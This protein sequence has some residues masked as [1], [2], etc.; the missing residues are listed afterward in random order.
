MYEGP[1][2]E[3]EEGGKEVTTWCSCGDLGSDVVSFKL[4]LVSP[5]IVEAGEVA[6]LAIAASYQAYH[7][8]AKRETVGLS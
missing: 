2:G 8:A 6:A 1:E 5:F 7:P 4:A 3:L